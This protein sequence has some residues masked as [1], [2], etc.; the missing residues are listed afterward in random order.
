[1]KDRRLKIL[2]SSNAVWSNSGYARFT[3]D[4]S[5]RMKKDDWN[6]RLIAWAGLGGGVIEHKGIYTYPQIGDVWGGDAMV[7]HGRHFGADV[8]FSMQDVHTINP[9]FLQQIP[10]WIPYC[11]IDRAEIQ[12]MILNNLKYAYK[13]I[14]FSKFGQTTLQKHGFA[15][16]LIPEGVDTSI[17][18]PLDKTKTRQELGFPTDKFIVGMIGANK[19]DGISRKGWEQALDGFAVFA[20]VH[21]EAMFFYEFN[22]GGGF[23][24]PGYAAM[25]GIG[26]RLITPNLYE[27][28]VH[29]DPV[30]VNKW[31]NSCDIILHPST[32]EG[33]GLVIAEAQAAGTPVIINNCH[34][35]PELVIEG[36][37]GEICTSNFKLWAMGGGYIHFPDPASITEKLELLYGKV[38]SDENKISTSCRSWIV[39]NYS[40]DKIFETK[41]VPFLEDL[42]TELLGAPQAVIDK[43]A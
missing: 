26:D 13:I 36:K 39:D 29:G 42:Q 16:Y 33:F 18:K 40:I 22:Q 9:Q 8:T 21:P 24:I 2:W 3:D 27:A 4:W 6:L 38:K 43:K 12:P 14:T 35:Q 20:K 34:S 17:F 28:V 7:D 37:T 41:W 19:P 31:L 32:T 1:M 5:Q 11:P 23:D 10:K 15:S 30:V 25:L